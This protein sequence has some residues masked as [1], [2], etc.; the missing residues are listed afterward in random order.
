MYIEY[1]IMYIY[2]FFLKIK[3]SWITCRHRSTEVS[4]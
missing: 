4:L 2:L 3:A 1:L